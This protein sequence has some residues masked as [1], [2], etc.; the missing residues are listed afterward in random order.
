MER[1][2]IK[3]NI[4]KSLLMFSLPMILGNFLQQLYNITDTFIVGKYLGSQ[5]LAAVG[6]SFTLMTFLTSI[7][8]GLCMGSGV[9]FSMF[10][11]SRQIDKLKES[12]FVSFVSIGI[13]ALVLEVICILGINQILKFMNLSLIHI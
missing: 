4:K 2:L 13:V 10:Y 1:S 5:A 11:G 12:F 3:G 7:I 6:S 8:L 9:L